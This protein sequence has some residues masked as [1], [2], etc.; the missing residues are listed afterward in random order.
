M[1]KL[2][3]ASGHVVYEVGHTNVATAEAQF[4]EIEAFIINRQTEAGRKS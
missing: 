2:T 3:G 4:A 1:I